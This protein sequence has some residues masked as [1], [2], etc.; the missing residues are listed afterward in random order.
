MALNTLRWLISAL[1]ALSIILPSGSFFGFNYKAILTF[2]CFL[3]L[4]FTLAQFKLPLR[5][6]L[7]P[8]LFL[9]FLIFYFLVSQINST[10]IDNAKSHAIAFIS[11]FIIAYIPIYTIALDQSFEAKYKDVIFYSA[12]I[13]CGIKSGIGLLISLNYLQ[14]ESIQSLLFSAFQFEFIGLDAHYFYRIHIPIDFLLPILLLYFIFFKRNETSS[15]FNPI[16]LTLI[17]SAIILS[18][19]RLLYFLAITSCLLAF[20][21]Y[22]IKAHPTR[23]AFVVMCGIL[24]LFI[25]LYFSFDFLKERFFGE[26]AEAS[27]EPRAEMFNALLMVIRDYPFFGKGLGAG[28]SNLIRFE[29]FPWYYE[30]QWMSF[31]AQFGAVGFFI[32]LSLTLFPIYGFFQRQINWRAFSII[33]LY[34]LWL[35][36]GIFN[37][38][39]LTSSAGVIFLFFI[40]LIF[41]RTREASC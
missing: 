16:Y 27:D 8:I 25:S 38:F 7:F 6:Y 5:I 28:A 37:G 9:I 10:P 15:L 34:L 32:I 30:L 21:D 35:G 19:S 31:F 2:L 24:L 1:I 22:F 36:V 40:L 26:M 41:N 29:E 39:M 13:Y 20:F 23:K 12:I 11:I 3:M 18:Y 14:P 33:L 4:F 17:L